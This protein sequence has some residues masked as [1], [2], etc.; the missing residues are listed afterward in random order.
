MV[1]LTFTWSTLRNTS[2]FGQ[3]SSMTYRPCGE[4]DMG[5]GEGKTAEVG[6]PVRDR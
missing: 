4:D 6:R 1:R 3:R 2:A 5:V